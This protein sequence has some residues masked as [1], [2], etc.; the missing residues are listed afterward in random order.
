MSVEAAS[1]NGAGRAQEATVAEEA[2]A[3]PNVLL[4]I[5]PLLLIAMI[6]NLPNPAINIFVG[7]LSSAYGVAPSTIGSMR[8]IGGGAALLVGFLIAP[9]LDR[10]PRALTVVIGLGFV[11]LAGALPLTG[12]FVALMLAFT[13]LGAALAIVMP[14]AQAA[15]GDFFSGPE[16]G[17]AASLVQASQ[18][19]ANMVAGPLLALPALVIGWQGAYTSVV[20]AACLAMALVAPRLSW[21][22]PRHVAR[23]GYRQAFALIAKAPGAVP[24][25][26]SSTVRAC[27][28][29]AWLAFLAATLTERFG[30]G[31]DVV[32]VF[33]FVG[34]GGVALANIV[35][36]RTFKGAG[37]EGR[38]WWAAPEPVLL[39]SLVAMIVTAPLIY[40]APTLALAMAACIAF[41]L[42]VGV[43]IAAIISVLM[44]R[45][46]EMRG[47]VMGLNAAGQ[48]VGIMIGTGLAG[49]GLSLGGYPALAA[50]LAAISAVA[51]GI[52]LVARR[53]LGTV[54]VPA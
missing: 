23:A 52:F 7:P 22:P 4:T 47:A 45:Y 43:G 18:V 13:A 2:V 25:L 30:A 5:W 38:R 41:C 21:Q 40:L 15:C 17:K 24:M 3:Q 26:L 53:S 27:T 39:V 42:N 11:A 16:A 35:A 32:A 34:A 44:A 12:E 8:G 14:A 50:L 9:L 54:T 33:W 6:G 1:V 19:L 48:N 36:S 51:L 28:I 31:V 29:Q 10:F 20:F 46:A 49:V 37:T